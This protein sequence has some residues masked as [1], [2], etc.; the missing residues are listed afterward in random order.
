MNK[1]EA[2][3]KK[4]QANGAVHIVSFTAKNEEFT[5]MALELPKNVKINKKVI[6]GIKP[7]FVLIAK[8]KIK[9]ISLTNQIFAKIIYLDIGK[10]LVTVKLESD[11]G[12][13]E[14]L[15]TRK[16]YD[17]MGL[18]KGEDAVVMIKASEISI[19]KVKDGI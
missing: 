6:L 15:I 17:M 4:I 5:M 9:E 12:T 18:S 19:V 3:V 14:S 8:N 1:I 11:I 10:L 7:S 13:F 2:T 16:A